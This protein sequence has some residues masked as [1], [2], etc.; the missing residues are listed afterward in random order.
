MMQIDNTLAFFDKEGEESQ[1]GTDKMG[2]PRKFTSPSK[3]REEV[4]ESESKIMK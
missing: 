1:F 3:I 2:S 4:K